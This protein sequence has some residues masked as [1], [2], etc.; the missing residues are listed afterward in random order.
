MIK[1][2]KSMVLHIFPCDIDI[3]ITFQWPCKHKFKMVGSILTMQIIVVT[4]YRLGQASLLSLS[5]FAS[6]FLHYKPSL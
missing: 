3:L 2:F 4:L 1:V 5:N 6:K